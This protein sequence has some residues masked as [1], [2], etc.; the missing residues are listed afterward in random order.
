M[1]L[2]FEKKQAKA[3]LKRFRSGDAPTVARMQAHLPRLAE[4]AHATLADAQ[5]VLARERGF[6]SWPKLKEHI[7]SQRPLQE[8]IVLFM[9][10]ATGGK[11]AVARRLL[12]QRPQMTEQ[13]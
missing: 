1:D 5:F 10:A 2:E 12:A 11:L 4:D 8:Q 6:D 13:R 7:E 9:R 3:L